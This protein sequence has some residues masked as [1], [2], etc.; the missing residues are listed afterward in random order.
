[1]QAII[2]AAGMGKR[3]GA[4]TANKTK[5]MVAIH[6]KTLIERC[7]DALVEN[8]IE[9]VILVVGYQKDKLKKLIGSSY[10]DI[11]VV[12]VENNIFSTTN[13]I[14]SVYLARHYLIEDDTILIESDL[15]FDPKLISILIKNPTENLALVDKYQN[16]MDGT[17]VKLNDDFSISHFISKTE[18]SYSEVNDYYKTVNIYK[19]SKSFLSDVYVPFLKA[20]VSALGHNE[21]YEQVLRVIANL[22][23]G[24]I[25]A[26]PLS[27]ESWY[28]IDDAQDLDIAT[29]IFSEPNQRYKL[30]TGRYG[31]YWRFEDLKDFCYLVNP[32]F[33][34]E[35]LNNEIKHNLPKLMQ[36]YPSGEQVQAMLAGK[37]FNLPDSYIVVGNGAA[38]LIEKVTA[39]LNDRFGL[40]RPTFEEYPE[41]FNNIDCRVPNAEGFAYGKDEI[42]QL[43]KKNNGAILINPDNPSGNFI[44]YKDLIYIL[45]FLKPLGKY[46]LVDESFIDFAEDGFESSLL[47]TQDL[48]KYPNLIV[49]KSI[50][51]SYGVGGLRLGVLAS[52]NT[53]LLKQIKNSLPVWNINSVSEFYLQIIGK[54]M[55]EYKKSCSKIIT[56]RTQL[57]MD[58]KS[59]PYLKPY[60]SQAN[61]ILCKV[62]GKDAAK[63]ASDM[64]NKFSILIKD[65]SGKTGI[66]DQYIR[67]AVRDTRDNEDLVSGFRALL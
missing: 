9:R 46:L 21:Y 52:S 66:D 18:F 44:P 17:V 14:Y 51:K 39:S 28:E 6:E 55:P 65:C 32:Y 1:M 3:L 53:D 37:M 60:N 15:V 49:I 56:A 7:L 45:D 34:P 20:Y 23:K 29:L 12:Y 25:K 35:S 64:C 61:Y 30:L 41:R 19:F 8:G 16:W 33:P 67:V 38:E 24:H 43:A 11:E 4:E 2:P 10:K 59:I 26:L 62:L 42:I 48:E 27:G 31:G 50:G 57:F 22:D 40:F 58:L 47:N 36:S 13:N 63:L 5:A 54:Y